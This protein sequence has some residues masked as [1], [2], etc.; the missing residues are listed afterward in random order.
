MVQAGGWRPSLCGT[1]GKLPAA[2]LLGFTASLFCSFS[3]SSQ[4][5]D[6]VFKTKFSPLNTILFN[7][8]IV[9]IPF[10]ELSCPI[11]LLGVL[12]NAQL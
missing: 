1:G 10:N 3:F 5:A 4:R 8:R 9:F 2:T 7:D 11:M 12:V 6:S